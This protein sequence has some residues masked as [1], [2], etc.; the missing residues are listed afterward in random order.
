L[1]GVGVLNIRTSNPVQVYQQDNTSLQT[2]AVHFP[3]ESLQLHEET[4]D[5]KPRFEVPNV[6]VFDD[7]TKD[8]ENQSI[9]ARNLISHR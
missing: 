4:V 7:K 9:A 2:E 8:G 5:V 6:V 1:A 3:T